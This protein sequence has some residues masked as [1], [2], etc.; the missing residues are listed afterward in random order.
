MD[1]F[2]SQTPG[3]RV[4]GGLQPEMVRA[5]G[6]DPHAV[7]DLSINVN[8]FGPS[9]AM[10][11][12]LAEVSVTTYPDPEH[13][14]AR[15]AVGESCGRPASEVLIGNGASELLWTLAQVYAG[16]GQRVLLVEPTF[17]EFGVAL[18]A[19]GATVERS[20]AAA[21][22]GFRPDL[23]AVQVMAAR[24]GH[25]VVHL[26]APGS[27]I[28]NPVAMQ[29]VVRLAQALPRA[30]VIVD[31]S[32]LT[33]STQHGELHAEVPENVVLL[34]SLTKDHGVPGLRIGYLLASAERVEAMS[35][36]RPT[37]SVGA[38]GQAAIV[39]AMA[40][41][42][43]VKDS[44]ERLVAERQALAEALHALDVPTLPSSTLY[45][46]A[47]VGDARAV[48]DACLLEHGVLLRDCTSFGLPRHVR[49]A[50]RTAATRARVC[51]AVGAVLGR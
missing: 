22:D 16:E 27:P 36:L 21:E 51:A 35:A 12:A 30:T 32:F 25:A 24:G 31:Q 5:R 11:R 43:F 4:H 13:R 3:A 14:L 19:H 10:R 26:C 50:A 17:S 9:D 6:I 42:A 49:I 44:R 20:M 15:A 7:L 40:D 38:H 1:E 33:M 41:G 45:L 34:R 29:E 48:A 8:P 2:R 18:A 47:H 28:G 46:C 39:A 23:Q 37:W